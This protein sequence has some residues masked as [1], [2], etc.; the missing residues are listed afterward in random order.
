MLYKD[1]VYDSII[2]KEKLLI[3]L[4]NSILNIDVVEDK[5]IMIFT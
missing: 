4:M 1:D 3:D 2:I 5:T